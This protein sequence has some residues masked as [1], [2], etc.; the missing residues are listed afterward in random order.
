MKRVDQDTVDALQLLAPGKSRT[1]GKKA[2]GLILS[3]QA[4]AGFSDEERRI[5]WDRMKDFDGLVPSLYTFFED[6]K[7]LENC[8]HCV[9]R[10][11][12]PLTESVWETMK[13]IFIPSS[14]SEAESIIQ[15][16]EST[17][18]RQR[19]TDLERLEMGYLQLWLYTMRHYPLMPPDLKKDDD[20]LAKPARAKA[21]ERTIYEMAELARRLGFESPEI[22]ALIGSSPDY[23]IARAALL[24]ARKPSRFRYHSQQFDILVSRIVDCFAEAVPDQPDMVHDLLADSTM[25]PRARCGMPTTRTHKQDSPLLFLDRLHA[26]DVGVTDM[27]T[28]FFVRRC[29]YFAFFGKPAR[30]GPPDSDLTGNSPGDMPWSPLFVAEDSRSGGHGFA[31]PAALPRE[32]PQQEREELQGQRARRDREKHT[33]RRQQALRRERG[34]DALKRRRT[35]KAQMRRR[36]SRPT[37]ESDQVPM[38]VEW[39]STEP[40]DQDMSDQGR[41]SPEAPIEVVQDESIPFDPATALTLHSTPGPAV[42]EEADTYSHCTRISL[43]GT[44]LERVSEDRPTIEGQ[45]HDDGLKEQA[46]VNHPS[47]PRS[48]EVED[49]NFSSVGDTGGQQPVLEEYLDQLMRAQEEQEKLEAELERERLEEELG[50]SNQEQRVPDPSPRPQEGQNSPV[51]PPDDHLA[52]VTRDSDL[53]QAALPE[54]TQDPSPAS[55]LEG[56]PDPPAENLE[57]VAL[58]TRHGA[59]NPESQNPPADDTGQPTMVEASPPTLVEIS[60]WTFEQE[61]W[62]QSDRLRVDP[63]DPSPVERVARKYTWKNYSLYDLNLQSLSP[64]QCYRAAT[65]DGNNAIFLVSEHEERKLAAEGRFVKDRKLL[66]L[67]SRVLNRTE[68]KSTT[69]RRRV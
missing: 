27:I 20:L 32:P 22:D 28:S 63:S 50:L 67:V 52:E 23:Q 40:S 57:H 3:G 21:D 24:Q 62:K 35:R 29:V 39:L 61:E 45:N 38:E 47:Q 25:K 14:D 49:G 17:F 66:S 68:P 58:T 37:G 15:T 54:R 6:F 5:I 64:A 31:M 43:E 9:K 13:S 42:P 19:A 41:S 7:Y 26:D 10:L 51:R 44:P 33:L 60:F 55:R 59:S 65:V 56:Q 36:Q 2:C 18:R 8:A 16:S 48:T 53:A 12:G 11:F 4:F 34:R 1:D 30:R 69:K 46:P